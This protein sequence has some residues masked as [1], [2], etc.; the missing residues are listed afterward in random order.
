[1]PGPHP[2]PEAVGLGWQM[3]ELSHNRQVIDDQ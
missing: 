2:D 3:W 1:M